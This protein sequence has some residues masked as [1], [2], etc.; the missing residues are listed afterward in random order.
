MFDI[1]DPHWGCLPQKSCNSQWE[2]AD[3]GVVYFYNMRFLRR[4]Y[5]LLTRDF[6]HILSFPFLLLVQNIRQARGASWQPIILQNCSSTAVTSDHV[7]IC[8]IMCRRNCRFE[9]VT[10]KGRCTVLCS[11]QIVLRVCSEDY[12]VLVEI[13]LKSVVSHNLEI[14]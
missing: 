10:T 13:I 6:S 5:R 9:I 12:T 11:G 7:P 4:L 8:D 3:R 14:D 1:Y 2:R